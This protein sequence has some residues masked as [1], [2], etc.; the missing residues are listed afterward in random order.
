MER[1]LQALF[2]DTYRRIWITYS[3]LG[4]VQL[5]L[6][7][8]NTHQDYRIITEQK[9]GEITIEKLRDLIKRNSD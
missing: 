1:E 8:V 6:F 3:R 9:F 7:P 5:T 2:A 4:T